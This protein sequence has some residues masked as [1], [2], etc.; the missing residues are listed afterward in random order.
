MPRWITHRRETISRVA[1]LLLVL[2][3][4]GCNGDKT[5]EPRATPQPDFHL[6]DVNANSSRT[7]QAVSPRDYV[8]TV[9][10]WYFGHS[11]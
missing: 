10:A 4:V 11:T 3:T 9:S 2:A 6:I 7:G 8:R 1:A 5:T